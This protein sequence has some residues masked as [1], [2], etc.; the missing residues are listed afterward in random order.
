MI[1]NFFDRKT[2]GGAI[3]NETMSNNELAEEL[4]KTI[5]R[6]FN[7]R[8]LQSTFIDNIWSTDLA[9]MEIINKFN[10]GICFSLCVI[11]IFSG[12][13]L[14]KIIKVLQLPMLFEKC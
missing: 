6:K 2:S 1:Y 11:D 13:F 10:K 3:N 14:W 4:H 8:K 12:L 5:I 7:K 9:D